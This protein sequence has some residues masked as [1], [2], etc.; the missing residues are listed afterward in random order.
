MRTKSIF[1]IRN[2]IQIDTDLFMFLGEY[3]S[4]NLG[5]DYRKFLLFSNTDLLIFFGNY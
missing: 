2:T 3:Y 5:T 1:N 4:I